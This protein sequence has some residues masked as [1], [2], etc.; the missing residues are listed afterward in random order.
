MLII[1]ILIVY[2]AKWIKFQ[3]TLLKYEHI[4]IL[5]IQVRKKKLRAK[6]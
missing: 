1:S 5:I 6:K 4:T 2:G 3:N